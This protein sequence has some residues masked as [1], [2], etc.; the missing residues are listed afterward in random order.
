MVS[1][2]LGPVAAIILILNLVVQP[3]LFIIPSIPAIK[4]T[5][6]A[7]K[8]VDKV[9]SSY[10]GYYDLCHRQNICAISFLLLLVNI[11]FYLGNFFVIV[12][13]YT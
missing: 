4:A 12:A 10:S 6:Q 5:F 1:T 9:R 11:L 2:L 13:M 8:A 7:K 3:F